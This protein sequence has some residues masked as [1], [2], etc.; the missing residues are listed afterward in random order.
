MPSNTKL[1]VNL[2]PM[3][4]ANLKN[5]CKNS[6]IIWIEYINSSFFFLK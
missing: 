1:N 2:N 5:N 6:K 4:I 3:Y